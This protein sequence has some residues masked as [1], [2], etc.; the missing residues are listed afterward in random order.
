LLTVDC[1]FLKYYLKN[2]SHD[3]REKSYEG[4]KQERTG[5]ESQG[6]KGREKGQTGRKALAIFI[7]TPM[8]VNM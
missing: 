1:T 7:I 6:K 3:E 2:I 5:K 4:Q 8:I